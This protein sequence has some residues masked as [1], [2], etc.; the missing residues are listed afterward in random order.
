MSWAISQHSPLA[1]ENCPSSPGFL[2]EGTLLQLCTAGAPGHGH[3]PIARGCPS[4]ASTGARRTVLATVLPPTA[5][6]PP[7]PTAEPRQ[8][9]TPLGSR[10]LRRPG[11]WTHHGLPGLGRAWLLGTRAAHSSTFPH[12]PKW[13][14]CQQPND[15]QLPQWPAQAWLPACQQPPCQCPA[16]QRTWPSPELLPAGQ[17]ICSGIPGTCSPLLLV[18]AQTSVSWERAWLMAQISHPQ[19]L[20]QLQLSAPDQHHT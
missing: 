8:V 2:S 10:H 9:R 7:C 5:P 18:P 4:Q 3:V 16:G 17:P 15:P 20:A 12:Q 13:P 11:L 1:S 6:D 19:A 14:V